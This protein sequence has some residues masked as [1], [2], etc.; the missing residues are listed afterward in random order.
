MQ[1]VSFPSNPSL[2]TFACKLHPSEKIHRIDS[3]GLSR[4]SLVCVE[5]VLSK[6]TKTKFP[7]E[8]LSSLHQFVEQVTKLYDFVKNFSTLE[9]TLPPEFTECLKGEEKSLDALQKHVETEKEKVDVA[10]TMISDEFLSICKAK[11][12]ELFKSLDDQYENLR[13]NFKYYQEKLDKYFGKSEDSSYPSKEAIYQRVNECKTYDDLDNVIR[14]LKDDMMEITMYGKDPETRSKEL[15]VALKEF[16]NALV[17]NCKNLPQTS[18]STNEKANEIKEKL[19]TTVKPLFEN[20]LEI[21]NPID[22]LS[23]SET[24]RIGS[25]IVTKIDEIKLLR[26]WI[27]AKGLVKF[28]LLYKGSKDG[29]TGDA[30]HKKCDEAKPTITIVRSTNKKVFGGYSDVTWGGPNNYKNTANSWLFSMD[31]KEKYKQKANQS[32][33]GVYCYSSYG[34]TWGGGHDIYIANN[35]NTGNSCYSNF[36]YTFDSKNNAYSTTQAQS[37]LAGSYNFTVEEIEVF[38]ILTGSGN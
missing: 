15:R 7:K 1:A 11:K 2:K 3:D 8:N 4:N 32:H 5:C 18:F 27:E 13:A 31:H 6:D 30:F 26:S 21:T 9:D 17:Q 20:I 36:G 19:Q 37:H 29:F 38:Q 24:G 34:P 28:K 22:L 33:Y 35:C 23:L 16:S 10:F 25:S 14:T 12:L